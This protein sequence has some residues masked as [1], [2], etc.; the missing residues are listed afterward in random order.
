VLSQN[1]NAFNKAIARHNQL[2]PDLRF[3]LQGKTMN[4]SCV[5]APTSAVVAPSHKTPRQFHIA[6]KTQTTNA[7]PNIPASVA[8]YAS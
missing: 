1:N 7:S 4:F 5:V 2:R 6:T 3:T 8:F